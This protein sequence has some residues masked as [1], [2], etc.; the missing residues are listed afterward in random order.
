MLLIAALA[1]ADDATL[2]ACCRAGGAGACPSTLRLRTEKSSVEAIGL[3]YEL[4]GAWKLSCSGRGAWDGTHTADLDADPPYGQLL[5]TVTPLAAHCFAQACGLPEG[6]CLGSPDAEGRF[7]LVECD[8]N[9]PVDHAALARAPRAQATNGKVVVIDGKP[10]VANPVTGT[11]PAAP[12]PAVTEWAS[13]SWTGEPATSPPVAPAPATSTPP[14]TVAT[15]PALAVDL[16]PDPPD[17]CPAA[18]DAVRGESRKRVG[19][20]D[21]FRVLGRLDDALRDYKAALTMDK[22][23]GYAWM[24]LSMLAEQQGR[25]DLAIRALKNTTRLLPAHPGAFLMLGRAYEAFGQR[26]LAAT[27]YRRAADLAPGNAEAIEGYMRTRGG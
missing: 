5:G 14:T 21:D 10:L 26:A 24:S 2:A 16:P 18:P 20:G 1:L 27:A 9:M 6:T 11:P 13:A 4:V 17:P 15:P 23:N 25:T 22:C 3:G 7:S 12:T 19:T 8:S